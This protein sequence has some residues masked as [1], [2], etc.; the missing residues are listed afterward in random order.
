LTSS[1]LDYA[2][3]FNSVYLLPIGKFDRS[4]APYAKKEHILCPDPNDNTKESICDAD[5][6]TQNAD[7]YSFHAAGVGFSKLCSRD[8][9]L[10]P[11]PPTTKNLRRQET[12]STI[13]V[14]GCPDDDSI[15]FDDAN[16][17]E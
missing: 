7:T 11:L 14:A 15:P 2:Y 6:S 4:C 1:T 9:P 17:E 10:P 5:K 8:I 16:L 12:N 13:A 3:G